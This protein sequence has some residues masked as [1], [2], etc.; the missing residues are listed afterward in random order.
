ME[1]DSTTIVHGVD[2]VQTQAA[3]HDCA[4]REVGSPLGQAAK[5]H[6]PRVRSLKCTLSET[7]AVSSSQ[8]CKLEEW[9]LPWEEICSSTAR[10]NS[11]AF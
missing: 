10:R 4:D 9:N 6:V 5:V 8:I 1:G 7:L 11:Q 3:L 2:R